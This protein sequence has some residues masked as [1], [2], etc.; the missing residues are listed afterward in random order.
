MNKKENNTILLVQ[1]EEIHL[2]DDLA[3]DNQ[4]LRV[5]G[6]LKIYFHNF[7]EPD[8]VGHN[9]QVLILEIYSEIVVFEGNNNRKEKHKRNKNQWV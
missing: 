1:L 3:E 4:M 8:E 7:E 6:D 9:R 5:L 2:V